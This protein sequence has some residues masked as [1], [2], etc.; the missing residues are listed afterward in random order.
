MRRCF[1]GESRTISDNQCQPWMVRR[2]VSGEREVGREYVANLA[3]RTLDGPGV[4]PLYYTPSTFEFSYSEARSLKIMLAGLISRWIK[5]TAWASVSASLAC[6]K[7]G[8]IATPRGASAGA[9]APLYRRSGRTTRCPTLA[10]ARC[11]A[12]GRH[13]TR[14]LHPSMR[15]NPQRKF[16]SAPQSSTPGG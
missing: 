1:V 16:A 9:R 14:Q 13:R 7:I 2:W 6:F 3:Y 15:F 4:Q 12:R 11:S 10:G 5:R 8:V